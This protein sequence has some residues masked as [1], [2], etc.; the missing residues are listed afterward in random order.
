MVAI[1]TVILLTRG[2]HEEGLAA[3]TNGL[4]GGSDTGRMLGIMRIPEWGASASLPC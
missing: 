1:L 3:T 2:Q 4:G